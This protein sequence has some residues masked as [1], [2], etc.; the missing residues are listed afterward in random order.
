[1]LFPGGFIVLYLLRTNIACNCMV[2]EGL[3]GNGY[4]EQ[5]LLSPKP[6]YQIS[7]VGHSSPATLC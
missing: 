2:Q 1:M 6:L 3:E 4:I 5:I 7:C